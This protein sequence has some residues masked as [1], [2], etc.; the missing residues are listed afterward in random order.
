VSLQIMVV[1]L[2]I[3]TT[4]VT[5]RA[6]RHHHPSRGGQQGR[7]A[8]HPLQGGREQ[9]PR[10]PPGQGRSLRSQ[11]PGAQLD[12]FLIKNLPNVPDPSQSARL[13]LQ[14]FELAP[15]APSPASECCLPPWFRRGGQTRLREKGANSDEGTDNTDE[16]TDAL[17]L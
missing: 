2:Q 1:T 12:I 9:G 14:S 7:P 15:P 6:P 5:C 16:G 13:S 11:G 3:V 4:F 10:P 8:L 17:I